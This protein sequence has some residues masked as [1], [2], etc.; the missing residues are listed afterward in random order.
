MSLAAQWVER[1]RDPVAFNALY[2]LARLP[3]L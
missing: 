3:P 2:A 1:T